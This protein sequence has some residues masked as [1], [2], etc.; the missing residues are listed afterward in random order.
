MTGRLWP[1]RSTPEQLTNAE[2]KACELARQD[3]P[4]ALIHFIN[5]MKGVD[6]LYVNDYVSKADAERWEVAKLKGTPYSP[7]VARAGDLASKTR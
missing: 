2:T 7:A 5:R 6:N 4:D 3:T 1:S